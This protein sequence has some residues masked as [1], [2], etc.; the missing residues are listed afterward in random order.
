VT[1]AEARES[2]KD[3]TRQES[4]SV[5]GG[6]TDTW[7]RWRKGEALISV[8]RDQ[9]HKG[10]RINSKSNLLG[11]QKET[12]RVRRLESEGRPTIEY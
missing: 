4:V 1:T 7:V 3:R 10:T 2:D 12:L 9:K 11:C 6:G 5:G 8:A